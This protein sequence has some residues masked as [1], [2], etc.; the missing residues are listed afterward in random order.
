M[1]NIYWNKKLFVSKGTYVGFAIFG[2]TIFIILIN[3]YFHLIPTS[4]RVSAMFAGISVILFLLG[5]IIDQLVVRNFNFWAFGA[6]VSFLGVAIFFSPVILYGIGSNDHGLWILCVIIGII[7]VIF[8]YGIEATE[9]N[10][11]FANK[12]Q[13]LIE[14]IKNY[15]WKQLPTKIISL[16]GFFIRSLAV[17]IFSGFRNFKTL[18]VKGVNSIYN[19]I[20]TSL[21]KIISLLMDLPRIISKTLHSLFEISFWFIVPSTI[22]I[23][24]IFSSV[25]EVDVAYSINL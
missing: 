10:K 23:G 17:Y 15:K 25:V 21:E 3:D 14:L 1:S 2:V 16:V 20:K 19:F 13:V 24:L 6:V 9:L 8:G 11:R 5:F 22:V 12:L 4:E 7:L 18:V